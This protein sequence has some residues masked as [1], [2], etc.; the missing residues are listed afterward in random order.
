[1]SQLMQLSRSDR[2]AWGVLAM[3]LVSLLG[4]AVF[5]K[6]NP[7]GLGTHQ[8]LGL[9]PCTFQFLLGI[10]CPACGMTTSWSYMMKGMIRNAFETS[11]S[12]TLLGML[13]LWVVPVSGWKSLSGRARK[14]SRFGALAVILFSVCL[15]V[16]GFEWLI[17]ILT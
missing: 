15:G 2:I 16:A 1:M 4:I 6:P 14:D 13:A 3:V 5:L 12:G 9:P 7:D 8:Q 11:S 17:R 10:R